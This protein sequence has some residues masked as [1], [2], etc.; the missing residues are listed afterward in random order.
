MIRHQIAGARINPPSVLDVVLQH[1][2]RVIQID[3]HLPIGHSSGVLAVH[4]ATASTL[5]A[6]GADLPVAVGEEI[7]LAL[8]NGLTEGT[9]VA[10]VG[11][12]RRSPEF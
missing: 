1:V 8:G 7:Y 3:C 11:T 6:I 9:R 4:L 12:A 10:F 5:A 2:A